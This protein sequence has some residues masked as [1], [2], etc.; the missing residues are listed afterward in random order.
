MEKLKEMRKKV[1]REKYCSKLARYHQNEV[2]PEEQR[3]D[4]MRRGEEKGGGKQEWKS[5]RNGYLHG[6]RHTTWWHVP[7]GPNFTW[8]GSERNYG[9]ITVL[10]SL[11]QLIE[12]RI[13]S[14]TW[15]K[16]V[17][18]LSGLRVQAEAT[19]LCCSENRINAVCFGLPRSKRR[20]RKK[21]SKRPRRN[22][23]NLPWKSKAMSCTPQ[24]S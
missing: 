19:T 6:N 18:S 15:T 11:P 9:N 12:N 17:A 7:P 16:S 24:S 8:E 3:P 13:S 5:K 14:W 21:Q 23:A 4:K 20:P 1:G 2:L 22:V 10:F